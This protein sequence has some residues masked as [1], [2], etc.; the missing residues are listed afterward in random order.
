MSVPYRLL[1]VLVATYTLMGCS[2]PA[3]SEE[4]RSS[5]VVSVVA[6]TKARAG[7]EVSIR[8]LVSNTSDSSMTLRYAGTP[9]RVYFDVRVS[10]MSGSTVWSSFRQNPGTFASLYSRIIRAGESLELVATWNLRNDAGSTVPVG[11]YRVGGTVT[12]DSP[13]GLSAIPVPI[14]VIP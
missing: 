8:L 13:P 14:R 2:S 4:G 5:L 1:S 7:A 10:D 3:A 9:D 11:T 6:P 12:T